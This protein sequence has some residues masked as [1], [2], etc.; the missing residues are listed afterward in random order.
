MKHYG[1]VGKINGSKI[2][3]VDIITF[4]APCQDLS[5][6]VLTAL[7]KY[8]RLAPVKRQNQQ[9]EVLCDLPG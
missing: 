7:T 5:V 1:D 8:E 9:R 6:N 3:P 2:E 4:G